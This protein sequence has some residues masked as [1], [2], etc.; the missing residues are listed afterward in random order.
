M[1]YGVFQQNRPIGDIH[2]RMRRVLRIDSASVDILKHVE[3]FFAQV[4]KGNGRAT[5]R[6]EAE[7][8]T[9]TV[10]VTPQFLCGF[11]KRERVT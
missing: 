11:V 1:Q 9:R 8:E 6:W 7:F 4:E 10:V 2:G 5:P 3:T